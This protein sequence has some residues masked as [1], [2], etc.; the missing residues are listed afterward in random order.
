MALII[1][2]PETLEEA[3]LIIS[4]LFKQLEGL[5]DYKKTHKITLKM[6]LYE[7]EFA[8]GMIMGFLAACLAD[9]FTA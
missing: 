1:T 2:P 4:G 5:N 6:R 3:E 7:F 8:H 9:L